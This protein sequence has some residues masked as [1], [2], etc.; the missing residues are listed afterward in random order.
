LFIF[1]IFIDL[2]ID[3]SCSGA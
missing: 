3:Q 1:S 2:V